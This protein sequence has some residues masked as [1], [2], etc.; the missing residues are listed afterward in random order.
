MTD[1]MIVLANLGRVKAYRVTQDEMTSTP[2]LELAD[3]FEFIESHERFQTRVSDQAG[4]LPGTGNGEDHNLTLE[5]ERR[6]LKQAAEKIDA[7]VAHQHAWYLAAPAGINAR[8]V[9]CLS[10]P[11]RTSLAKN[12]QADLVKIP[13]QELSGHFQSR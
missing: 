11:A 7:L 13:S 5:T 8:L 2:H 3:D 1:K 9:E 10:A 12:V 6:I 4:H